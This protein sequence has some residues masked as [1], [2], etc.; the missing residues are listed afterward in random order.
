MKTKQIVLR[1]QIALIG[2]AYEGRNSTV[3]ADAKGGAFDV[4][5]DFLSTAIRRLVRGS[6]RR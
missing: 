5:S 1:M 2:S 6:S 4:T 3:N